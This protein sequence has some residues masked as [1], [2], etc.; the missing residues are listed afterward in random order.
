MKNIIEPIV[1]DEIEYLN[2]NDKETQTERGEKL[3]TIMEYN[4]LIKESGYRQIQEI[5]T[6]EK[7]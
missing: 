3:I 5:I 4:A 7:W 1:L 2:N 6:N